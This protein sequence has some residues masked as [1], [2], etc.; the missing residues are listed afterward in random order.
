MGDFV[1][2]GPVVGRRASV[3]IRCVGCRVRMLSRDSFRP[4]IVVNTGS[5][6]SVNRVDSSR[7]MRSDRSTGNSGTRRTPASV[8][9]SITRNRAPVAGRSGC[10]VLSPRSAPSGSMGFTSSALR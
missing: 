6:T 8:F 2:L 5:S 1:V 3:G 4:A 7:V 9:E 10:G